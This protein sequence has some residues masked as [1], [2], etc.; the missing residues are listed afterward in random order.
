MSTSAPENPAPAAAE[1]KPS[2][3]APG[4]STRS[5]EDKPHT[6]S[7]KPPTPDPVANKAPAQ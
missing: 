5:G 7:P 6:T 4:P 3:A 1:T 2:G